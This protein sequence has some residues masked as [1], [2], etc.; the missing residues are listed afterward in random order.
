MRCVQNYK[1]VQLLINNIMQEETWMRQKLM[2]EE[3]YKPYC[4]NPNC[5]EM[6]RTYFGLRTKQFICPCCGWESQYPKDFI[7]RYIKKWNIYIPKEY[8]K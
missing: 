1:G 5:P 3:G 6:P 2:D 4:G 7:E 8:K